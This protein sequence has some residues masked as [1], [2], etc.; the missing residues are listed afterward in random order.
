LGELAVTGRSLLLDQ[1]Q[2][3]FSTSTMTVITGAQSTIACRIDRRR[4]HRAQ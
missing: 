1:T 2:K 3:D 4:S